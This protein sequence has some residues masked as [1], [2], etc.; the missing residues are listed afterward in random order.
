[1]EGVCE[2]ANFFGTDSTKINKCLL[3]GV[4]ETS[5]QARL[6]SSQ[7]TSWTSGS[8]L[9]CTLLIS[10]LGLTAP[11]S[12]RMLIYLSVFALEV[13]H[14]FKSARWLI[15]CHDWLASIMLDYLSISH[16]TTFVSINSVMWNILL[17][18]N[19]SQHICRTILCVD[20]AWC[21]ALASSTPSYPVWK[22]LLSCPRIPPC[23][24]HPF[25]CL[26]SRIQLLSHSHIITFHP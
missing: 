24:T 10:L 5:K 23:L 19:C 22:L 12:P 8:G 26:C 21:R 3:S 6:I 13:M 17:Q 25:T 9:G 7:N 18:T 15:G 14:C 2:L 16:R 11:C 4:L 20:R 1:M